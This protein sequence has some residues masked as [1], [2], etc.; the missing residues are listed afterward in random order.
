LHYPPVPVHPQTEDQAKPTQAVDV[1]TWYE[2]TQVK[3]RLQST[4]LPRRYVPARPLWVTDTY[5]ELGDVGSEV[6]RVQRQL[7]QLN[8]YNGPING[9]YDPLTEQAV[10]RFQRANRLTQTGVVGPTTQTYLFNAKPPAA[11]PEKKEETE[12][13]NSSS[14]NLFS[15]PVLSRQGNQHSN[16]PTA[17]VKALQ[18]RLS[19]QGLYNGPIDGVYND[20]TKI[21]VTS[22]KQLYGPSVN[23]ILF[24]QL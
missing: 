16:I 6:R 13:T 21:A 4:S 9:F 11:P 3:P 24:G 17:S 12:E 2:Q 19:I 15:Q 20:Q 1:S 22:A 7:R 18:E 5:L 14:S 23:D 8:F 10:I